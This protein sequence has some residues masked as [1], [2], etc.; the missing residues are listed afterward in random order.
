[1]CQR[2]SHVRD[3]NEIL[4]NLSEFELI[5]AIFMAR[6]SISNE[7][8]ILVSFFFAYVVVAHFAGRQLSSVQSTL[9]TVVYSVFVFTTIYSVQTTAGSVARFGAALYGVQPDY[10]WAY[11]NSV[12]FLFAWALTLLYMFQVRRA[13]T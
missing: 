10:F 2:L 5:E 6:S 4:A 11:T 1:M 7:S 9:L 12:F 8:T 3:P 13:D